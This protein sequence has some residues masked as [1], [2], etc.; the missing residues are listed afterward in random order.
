MPKQSMSSLDASRMRRQNLSAVLELVHRLRGITRAE[1]TRILGLNRSTIGDLVFQLVES[2]WVEERSDES[3]AGVGRPSPLVV[4]ANKWLVAAINPEVD[5][6]DIALVS[7]GGEVVERRRVG[8]FKPS[9]TEVAEIVAREVSDMGSL[10]IASKVLAAG[11][12]VPGLVRRADG[13]VRLAPGLGWR[14]QPLAE[15]L[16]QGLGMPV[17]AANDAHLGSRAELNF[18][19]GQGA[20][21]ML[22]LNGGPSGIGGG[23]VIAG[24]AVD[25]S[26]GYAGEIG[27]L[28]VDPSGES[29]ACGATGCLEATVKRINL[30]DK[31]GLSH[32]DDDELETSLLRAVSD[33]EGQVIRAWVESQIAWL[34][35]ALRSVVNLL[36]P[37]RIILGGHLASLWKAASE[38]QRDSSLSQALT[39]SA[40]GVEIKV[41]DLGSQRL[42]IGAAELA[43]DG[44]IDDP[45]ESLPTG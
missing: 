19:A 16:S 15:K 1:L 43:W 39:V 14:E 38:E 24:S 5:V 7:L 12:A 44:V 27:H 42:L 18:G 17:L 35:V 45:I 41:A 28:S 32:P 10:H 13:V 29:C 40:A 21:S 23:I 33:A 9:V 25:G 34:S 26:S 3:R 8:V 37:E 4:P 36:N 31:L 11:V 6:V 20:T 2:G 30:V 22:Y